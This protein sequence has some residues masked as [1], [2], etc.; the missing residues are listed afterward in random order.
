M[1]II[2]SMK[3]INPKRKKNEIKVDFISHS[4]LTGADIYTISISKEKILKWAKSPGVE[5]CFPIAVWGKI[6]NAVTLY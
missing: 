6:D 3:G 1:R 4:D 5:I 2:G